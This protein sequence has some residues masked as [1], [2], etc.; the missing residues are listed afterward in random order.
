MLLVQL[1][2]WF[3]AGDLV[4]LILFVAPLSANLN[5]QYPSISQC[6]AACRSANPCQF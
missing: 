2:L 6:Q 3:S 1:I 5:L 4:A